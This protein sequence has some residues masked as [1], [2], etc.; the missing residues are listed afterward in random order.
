MLI[1]LGFQKRL[2][3][4]KRGMTQFLE[5]QLKAKVKSAVKGAI[6][7]TMGMGAMK[8]DSPLDGGRVGQRRIMPLKFK[9]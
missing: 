9:F 3:R 1:G 5:N 6:P 8:M 2:M 7:K 4:G